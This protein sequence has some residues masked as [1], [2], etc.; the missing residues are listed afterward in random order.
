MANSSDFFLSPENLSYF[1]RSKLSSSFFLLSL[2]FFYFFTWILLSM[3]CILLWSSAVKVHDSQAYRKIDVTRERISR[4][5]DLR[6]IL[7]SIQLPLE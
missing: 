4:I 3:A 2:F 5:L 7:L 1:L 6:E